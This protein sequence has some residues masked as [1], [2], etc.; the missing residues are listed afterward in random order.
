M[1]VR[2]WKHFAF[3]DL[4]EL[5]EITD[6]ANRAVLLQNDERRV[7]M[8]CGSDLDGVEYSNCSEPF[9]FLPENVCVCARNSKRFAMSAFFEVKV[10]YFVCG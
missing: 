8:F 1:N 10:N 7:S 6:P 2:E 4:A 9:A 3:Q 5:T